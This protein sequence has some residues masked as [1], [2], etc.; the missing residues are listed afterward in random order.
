MYNANEDTY[1]GKTFG[2]LYEKTLKKELIIKD[3]GFN[4]YMGKWLD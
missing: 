2:E 1:F 3:K 4:L